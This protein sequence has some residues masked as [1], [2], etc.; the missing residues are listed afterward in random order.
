MLAAVTTEGLDAIDSGVR[1]ALDTSAVSDD[2]ILNMLARRR[3][4]PAPLAIVTPGDL[5]LMH[6]PV[7]NCA[8]YDS[9]RGIRAAA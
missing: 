3:E 8:R 1:E 5:A 4:P 2:V 6:L 9:L 7:A